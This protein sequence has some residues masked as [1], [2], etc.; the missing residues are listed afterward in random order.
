MPAPRRYCAVPASAAQ[1]ATLLGVLSI[2]SRRRQPSA[3]RSAAKYRQALLALQT[4]HPKRSRGICGFLSVSVT[5]LG[6][7][8][9]A[10]RGWETITALSSIA[11]PAL[12]RFALLLCSRL[13]SARSAIHPQI[14]IPS[15]VEGSA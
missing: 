2:F 12:K 8:I 7:P 3:N 1:A 14:V 11:G 9:L 5:T 6:C 10:K 15:A 4:C 13:P